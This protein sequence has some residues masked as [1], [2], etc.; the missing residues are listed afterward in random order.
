MKLNRTRGQISAFEVGTDPLEL[1][2][3]VGLQHPES[4]H[5][6][7]FAESTAKPLLVFAVIL[8]LAGEVGSQ[9]VVGETSGTEGSDKLGT[10]EKQ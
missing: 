2:S 9:H 7:A 3:I 10:Q 1:C 5:L 4:T 6:S 8:C